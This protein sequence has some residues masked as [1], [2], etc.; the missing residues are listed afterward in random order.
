MKKPWKL[1]PIVAAAALGLTVLVPG[2]I[3]RPG[4]ASADVHNVTV[5]DATVTSGD[6]I[7]VTV[8]A[9]QDN[10]NDITVNLSGASSGTS[11][12]F[13]VTDCNNCISEGDTG[14]AFTIDG[15]DVAANG[16]VTLELTITC[17]ADDTVS[18]NAD[19]GN[20]DD[21]ATVECQANTTPTVTPTVTGTPPTSTPTT[22][23]TPTGDTITLSAVQ[24]NPACGQAVFLFATVKNN[25]GGFVAGA[26]VTFTSSGGG[27]FSP[28]SAVTVTDGVA[29]STFTPPTSGNTTLTITATSNG[30][31]ATAT[32]PVNCS[33]ATSTPAPAAPTATPSGGGS[34]V[35]P[36]STGDA[37]LAD[38]SSN[39][40]LYAGLATIVGTVFL[41]ALVVARRRA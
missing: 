28:A 8:D 14:T 29:S 1:L 31:T 27:S 9:D 4:V 13:K 10:A 34:V 38:D 20:G 21:N 35:R 11:Y 25:Q 30:K 17:T 3:S 16:N 39:F 41:G 32:V 7:T 33:N 37:G 18:V 40:G 24:P 22:T 5:S 23:T 36:P 6:T 19:Q 15:G 2:G 26:N 12:Q